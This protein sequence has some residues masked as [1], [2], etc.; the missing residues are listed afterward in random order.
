[1]EQAQRIWKKEYFVYYVYSILYKE[2]I[3]IAMYE[4][5]SNTV[6]HNYAVIAVS[7]EQHINICS[8]H[9]IYV[10]PNKTNCTYS[11]AKLHFFVEYWML[12]VKCRWTK[13]SILKS[14]KF[15]PIAYCGCMDGMLVHARTRLIDNEIIL[16]MMM[17]FNNDDDELNQ[18]Y[19][20]FSMELFR[21][22]LFGNFCYC[23]S[24]CIS[25][26]FIHIL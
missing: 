19:T 26:L 25:V 18:N 16:M 9:S 12:N 5:V 22:F 17:S 21:I 14:S 24:L 1:M 2:L 15:E 10:A 4:C 3:I 6:M 23:V 7:V 20:F 11:I 13:R 8:V